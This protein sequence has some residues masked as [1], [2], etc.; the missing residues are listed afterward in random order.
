LVEAG[1]GRLDGDEVARVVVDDEDVSC[2]RT[3]L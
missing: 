3:V 2:V 1:E